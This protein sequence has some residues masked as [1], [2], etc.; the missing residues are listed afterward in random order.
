MN[1][2]IMKC[3]SGGKA[4]NPLDEHAYPVEAWIKVGMGHPSPDV[5]IQMKKTMKLPDG[6]LLVFAYEITQ[7]TTPDCKLNVKSQGDFY[8]GERPVL[9]KITVPS[10]GDQPIAILEFMIFSP[11]VVYRAETQ[12]LY[13][14][15]PARIGV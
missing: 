5:R 13:L 1:R 14:C 12:T 6:C 9:N 7:E 10:G 3:L 4:N 15:S 2:D 8:A 11:C